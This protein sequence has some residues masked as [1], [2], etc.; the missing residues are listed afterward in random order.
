MR[1][2]TR[3]EDEAERLQTLAEYQLGTERTPNLDPIVDMAAAMFACPAAAVN[4]IGDDRV[5]ITSSHGIDDYNNGRD[6]SFCAHAITQSEVFV[7][8]DATLDPRFH[9]NPI[10][11]SGFIR[12]YAG[13]PLKSVSGHALGALCVIDANPRP[14]FTDDDR[15]RLKELANLVL[16]KLELRRLQ[17]AADARASAFEV[18]AAVSP[19][20]IISFDEKWTITSWN[21]AASAMFQRPAEKT[22]GQS[23]P[24]L[25]APGDWGVVATGVQ[26][27]I[28]G[29][30]AS[31]AK[32]KITAVRRGESFPAEI[33]FLRWFEGGTARF[34][35]IVEDMTKAKG[36]HEVLYR[37]ANY[38]TLTGLPNRNM[39]QQAVKDAIDAGAG[40]GLIITELDGF[41]DV[42]N[43]LGHAA[44][45]AVLCRVAERIAKI[46]RDARLVARIGGDEFATLVHLSDPV[47]LERM[48]RQINSAIAQPITVDGSEVIVVGNSGMAI[49]PQHGNV[50]EDLK[51]SAK[52]ALFQARSAGQ[53]SALLFVPALRA[54]AIARR[55]FDAELHRALERREFVLFYQPQVT[56]ADNRVIGAEALIRWQHPTRG[57][58][59]PSAFLPALEAGVL[60]HPVGTYVLETACAQAAL[61]REA[62]RDFCI[63]VNLFAAQFRTS[64]L[65]QRVFAA[66]EANGLP[67]DALEL[68]ITENIML[69]QQ[70]A[71]H[72]QATLLAER[73]VTLS[74]D[75]FGTGHASLNLLRD[76]PVS[77]IKVDKSFT[78][79]VQTS[80]KDRA[81]VA[82]IIDLASRLGLRVVAEGIER[83]EDCEF[84]RA[85]GCEKGQGYYFG[86]PVPAAVFEEQFLMTPALARSAG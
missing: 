7:V 62:N 59:P 5:F 2:P 29:K 13:V 25:V 26:D 36:E 12:F 65:E 21:E 61:W 55:M 68:E 48:A 44:G 3:L 63:S 8:E 80:S 11:T 6:V 34:G 67:P 51:A 49:A 1:C 24:A 71:V 86:K 42:N 32:S 60:A 70:A 38:D 18:S 41:T 22:I 69:D 81:I 30:G 56:L 17:I 39:L 77:R 75:D 23:L 28:D 35:V 10:V 58:L 4:I 27:L 20:A 14:R 66:L 45:D 47:E 50:F 53:G 83:P 57:L 43:T 76:F 46:G 40:C 19:K 72:A 37:L 9:D 78:Q 79:A 16:D 85:L 82:S 54:E 52:L 64:D 84:L 33:H 74:L 73:G 15:M 31:S